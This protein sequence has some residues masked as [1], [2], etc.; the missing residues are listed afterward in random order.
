M[1]K[2]YHSGK[3]GALVRLTASLVKEDPSLAD[4]FELLKAMIFREMPQLGNKAVCPNCEASMQ[5]YTYTFDALDAKLLLSM[6]AEVRD[7]IR[8][9]YAF[10]EANMVRVQL[11]NTSYSIKCRT[12]IASKLGLISQVINKETKRRMPGQWLVTT[13]GWEA[14]RGEKVPKRVKVWRCHIEERFGELTTLKEALSTL[15][16]VDKTVYNPADWFEVTLHEG[17]LI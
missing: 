6:A 17:T 5:E 15:P 10:T 1:S 11:L 9:G 8:A 2:E 3:L 14:L 13:R 16:D 4:N 7:R 12:T